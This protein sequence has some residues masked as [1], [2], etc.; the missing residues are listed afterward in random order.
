[1]AVNEIKVRLEVLPA[2]AE[3][4][5]IEPTVYENV[6]GLEE[7]GTVSVGKLLNRLCAEYPRFGQ[8]VFD[9]DSQK[10]RDRV[11]IFFN[12]RSLDLADGLDTELGDGDTLTFVPQIVGG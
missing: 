4:L 2:L 5:D 11:M 10:L 3:T 1:M 9:V 6:S 12:G 7:D 8:M